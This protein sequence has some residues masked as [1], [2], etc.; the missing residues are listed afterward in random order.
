MAETNVEQMQGEQP[1]IE[2]AQ[3]GFK[4]TVAIA[5]TLLALPGVLIAFGYCCSSLTTLFD[6]STWRDL[7]AGLV[8]LSATLLT[9]GAGSITAWHGLRALNGK[10]S[11]PMRLPPIWALVGV[12]ALLIIFGLVAYDPSRGLLALSFAPVLWGTAVLP[13]LWAVSWFISGTDTDA[14][15]TWRKGMVAL[16][17]GA[18][19]SVVIALVLE[20]LVP[21]V[22]LLLVMDL[23]DSAISSVELLLEA[24]AGKDVAAAVTGPGFIYALIQ[25]AIVAPLVEEFAKPLITLPLL[26]R[27]TRRGAFLVGAMAGVGFATL[28]NVLYAGFAGQF[29]AG[30]ILVRALCGA[31]HPLGAGLVTLGWH[32]LFKNRVDVWPRAL[33]HFASAAGVHAIWNGG[34][35][36]VLTLAGAQFFDKLPPEIDVLG[37][38][39]AG[40][41][42]ALLIVLGLAALWVGRTVTRRLPSPVDEGDVSEIPLILPDRSVA[43]WALLCLVAFLP[44]GIVGLQL[45]FH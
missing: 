37:L 7:R 17:G 11:R 34:T 5:G 31:I 24:L 4:R 22:F 15:L 42:L 3:I 20:I 10:P 9:W 30:I 41:T 23:A 25:L 29:W 12:F 14:D 6:E 44:A 38:S 13:P 39:A 40:T 8:W 19:V 2:V 27:L 33:L 21:A 43:I 35:L 45:L 1:K 32:D 36:L 28:E 26:N 18:T 16:A